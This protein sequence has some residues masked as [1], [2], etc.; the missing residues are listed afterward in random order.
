M[1]KI[2]HAVI[3]ESPLWPSRASSK[4]SEDLKAD[5]RFFAGLFSANNDNSH[6]ESQL[7]LAKAPVSNC[8]A[9]C[10]NSAGW[11]APVHLGGD[12]TR[13]WGVC[14][15]LCRIAI[16]SLGFRNN[17]TENGVGRL[18]EHEP[19]RTAFASW[20]AD[21]PKGFRSANAQGKGRAEGSILKQD[22]AR[23]RLRLQAVTAARSAGRF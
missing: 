2:Y 9:V 10:A 6:S 18:A 22:K 11:V 21:F 1:G 20:P 12:E 17:S 15:R 23:R 19:P 7:Q 8:E 13:C 14:A 5:S 16:L 3:I 4:S